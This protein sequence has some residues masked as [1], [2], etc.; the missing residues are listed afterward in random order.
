MAAAAFQ[1]SDTS[2]HLNAVVSRDIVRLLKPGTYVP[3]VRGESNTRMRYVELKSGIDKVDREAPNW[4]RDSAKNLSADDSVRFFSKIGMSREEYKEYKFLLNLPLYYSRLDTLHIFKKGHFISFKGS[5]KLA[6]L[7][8][9]RFN[10]ALNTVQYNQYT[11]RYVGK[12]H[13]H[14]EQDSESAP[15]RSY[16]EYSFIERHD[17]GAITNER[18]LADMF[19]VKSFWLHIGQ[20]ADTKKI[21]LNFSDFQTEQIDLKAFIDLDLIFEDPLK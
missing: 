8:A 13:G 11:L 17:T 1:S 21:V 15:E 6:A 14:E 2:R 9:V 5:G 12:N 4:F 10:V 18:N 20:Q 16:Y 19:T 7:N 3:S